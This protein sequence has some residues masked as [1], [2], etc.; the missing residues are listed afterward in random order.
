MA[1]VVSYALW[2]QEAKVGTRCDG[3]ILEVLEEAV[4]FVGGRMDLEILQTGDYG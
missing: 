2:E 4:F 3:R 1:L